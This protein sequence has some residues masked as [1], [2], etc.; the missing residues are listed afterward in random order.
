MFGVRC[1]LL[2]SAEQPADRNSGK[3]SKWRSRLSDDRGF[4]ADEHSDDDDQEKQHHESDGD[5]MP[6]GFQLMPVSLLINR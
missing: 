1:R 4:L 5:D 6:P 3:A 2:H